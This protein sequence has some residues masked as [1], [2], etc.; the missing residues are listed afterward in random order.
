MK[1]FIITHFFLPVV[2]IFGGAFLLPAQTYANHSKVNNKDDSPGKKNF[3]GQN[4]TDSLTLDECITAALENNPDIQA[5]VNELQA[6]HARY[7]GARSAILPSIHFGSAYEYYSNEQRVLQPHGTGEQGIFSNQ[8]AR[9]DAVLT[10]PVFNGKRSINNMHAFS[11]SRKA[12]EYQTQRHKNI[13]AFSVSRIFHTIIN[14]ENR[15]V[16]LQKSIEAMESHHKRISSMIE[17]K[18]AA[19]LDL[20]RTNV[21]LASLHQQK[22]VADNE[23]SAFRSQLS[24]IMT[25][26]ISLR[27]LTIPVPADLKTTIAPVDSLYEQALCCRADYLAM[28]EMLEAQM[29]RVDFAR[30]ALA[31]SISLKG[32]YGIRTDVSGKN[33]LAATAALSLSLPLFEG[34]RNTAKINEEK[35][36]LEAQQN[37]VNSLSL[38]IFSEIETALL[39]IHAAKERIS[40]AQTGIDA[41]REGLRIENV[42]YEQGKGTISNVLDAQAELLEAETN[43]YEASSAL[44]IAYARLKLVSGEVL[45]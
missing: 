15:L 26:N 19:S 13:L 37:R 8:L 35:A 9:A 25:E 30:G 17:A 7:Q 3:S 39:D 11:H 2:L 29:R 27:P 33:E 23:I 5:A 42:K 41:A 24:A 34:G 18:K 32:G 14:L 16:S 43:Q 44:M 10:I 38:Q 4:N 31:P 45:K 20:L 22:L 6:A 36:L 12:Q 1:S 28:Q 21:R 40:I